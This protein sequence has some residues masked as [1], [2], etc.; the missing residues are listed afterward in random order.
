MADYKNMTHADLYAMRG[1][2]AP[3]DPRQQ[4]IAP[5]EHRAFAREWTQ[6]SPV[7]GPISLAFAVPGYAAAKAVGLQKSRTPA[8]WSQVYQGYAGV[9]DGLR[10]ILSK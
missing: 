8:S 9:A 2:L 5:Y 4:E 10:D 7:I 1:S 6:K 3:N